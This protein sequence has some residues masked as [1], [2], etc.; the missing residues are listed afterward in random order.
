MRS[1]ELKA[2]VDKISRHLEKDKKAMIKILKEYCLK[3]LPK[4]QIICNKFRL[5]I[6]FLSQFGMVNNPSLI[7]LN[8]THIRVYSDAMGIDFEITYDCLT[9]RELV[10]TLN[11]LHEEAQ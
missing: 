4:R 5:E 9:H 6:C 11:V 3:N 1:T 10:Q 8:D 7:G 2:T